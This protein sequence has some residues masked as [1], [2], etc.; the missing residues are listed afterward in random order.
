MD[1]LKPQQRS[2][3]MRRVPNKNTKPERRVRR[4]LHAIGL[5]FRL[6]RKNLPGQPDIVLPKYKTVVF[7]HG[8]FWHRHRKCRLASCPK[9]NCD[10]WEKKFT[11]NMARDRRNKRDLTRLGW[12]WIVIW[13]CQTKMPEKLAALV[14]RRLSLR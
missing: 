5:R 2:E 3:L 10:F 6:H 12:K 1:N 9:E 13:E 11:G 8:C 14:R 4:V 7:V